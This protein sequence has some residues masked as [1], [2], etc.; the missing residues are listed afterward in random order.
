MNL[1]EEKETDKKL[2]ELYQAYDFLLSHFG[3]K[4]LLQT[5]KEYY[6][7]NET[8]KQ[9]TLV[10]KKFKRWARDAITRIEFLYG[11]ALEQ[12]MADNPPNF[13]GTINP[14]AFVNH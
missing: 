13:K 5:I 14:F 11:R 4:K 10:Y 6:T 1:L 7:E 3:D 8:V 12:A 9:A 2:E